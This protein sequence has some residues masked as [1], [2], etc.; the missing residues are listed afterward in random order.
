MDIEGLKK[1]CKYADH[2]DENG[3]VICED[4][5]GC[6]CNWQVKCGAYYDCDNR[7]VM[8]NMECKVDSKSEWHDRYCTNNC[9][10]CRK[11]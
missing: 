4:G 10:T 7:E 5:L 6:E 1:N 8:K 3:I 11:Q 2:L 9:T